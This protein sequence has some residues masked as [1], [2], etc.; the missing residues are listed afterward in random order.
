MLASICVVWIAHRIWARFALFFL[1]SFFG[2][3]CPHRLLFRIKELQR[4]GNP[5]IVIALSGNKLDLAEQRQ[6][7]TEEAKAYADENGILFVETSAK[8]N[9]MVN[10]MFKVRIAV[11]NQNI[12]TRIDLP[13]RCCGRPFHHAAFS[14]L[15]LRFFHPCFYN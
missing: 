10:E 13:G 6:V 7:E 9:H 8:T 12:T 3:L 1:F 2:C 15:R 11:E 14:V 4:Q 5:S